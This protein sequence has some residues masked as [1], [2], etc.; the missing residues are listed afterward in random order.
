MGAAGIQYFNRRIWTNG[1]ILLLQ[2]LVGWPIILRTI[3]LSTWLESNISYSMKL[4]DCWKVAST[5]NSLL[6]LKQYPLSDKPYYLRPQ[7]RQ[8]FI[9]PFLRARMIRT[10]GTSD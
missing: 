3:A 10:S 1:R 2:L 4:I 9:K 5:S 8:S 7:V 6:S